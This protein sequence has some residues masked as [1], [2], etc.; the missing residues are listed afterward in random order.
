MSRFYGVLEGYSSGR[1]TYT[2]RCGHKGLE[3]RC[4]TYHNMVIT[5]LEHI[6]DN[7]DKAI[8]SL[9]SRSRGPVPAMEVVYSMGEPTIVIHKQLLEQWIGKT[10]TIL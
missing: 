9:S 7:L 10:I 4:S 8:V 1:T 3:A 5:K 2:T 6:D